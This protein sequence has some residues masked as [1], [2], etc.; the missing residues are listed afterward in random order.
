MCSGRGDGPL[1]PPGCPIR[2]SPDH[3]LVAGSPGLIAGSYVLLRLLVPRHPPCAL[4]NLATTDDARVHCAVLKIRPAPA[5]PRTRSAAGEQRPGRGHQPRGRS[6]RTQQRAR[7][8]QP[9]GLAFHTAAQPHPGSTSQPGQ[10]P[11]PNNQRSTNEQPPEDIRPGRGS[12]RHPDIGGRQVL[13]RKEVIQPHL[14]VRLP[15]YD[16]VPIAGPTFDGSL[17]DGLGHR[18]RVLPTFVT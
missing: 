3:S 8:A 9:P 2:T 16:F 17:P 10:P 4:N 11:R 13:L 7:P 12:G 6:L 15:C 5:T 1:R 18:L 14:P